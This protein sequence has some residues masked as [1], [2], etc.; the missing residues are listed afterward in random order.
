MKFMAL[1]FMGVYLNSFISNKISLLRFLLSEGFLAILFV[2]EGFLSL[3]E[4]SFINYLTSY[5]LSIGVFF[6][7]ILLDQ[8]TP[9]ISAKTSRILNFTAEI[10]YPLYLLHAVPG[11]V[12]VYIL[13][14]E[15]FSLLFGFFSGFVITSL[16]SVLLHFLVEKP[17]RDRWSKGNSFRD[18]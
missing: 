18:A 11:Y 15:G 10:S 16:L 12:I 8:K 9:F 2:G 13:H 7:L 17:F 6:S 4:T 14:S 5:S 1:I 3:G